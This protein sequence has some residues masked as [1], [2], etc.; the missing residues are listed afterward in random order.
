MRALLALA[1]APVARADRSRRRVRRARE[2]PVDRHVPRRPADRLCRA[3]PGPGRGAADRRSCRRRPTRVS[4]ANGVDQRL[5]GCEFVSNQRLVCTIWG[6]LTY[7]GTLVPVSR[8]VALNIDGSNMRVLGERDTFNQR[9]VRTF[10]GS[11]ID[12][13]PGQENS[14]LMTQ[15]FI[16]DQVTGSR[17]GRR[18]EGLG[19]VRVDTSNLRTSVVE[20]PRDDAVRYI[21]DG[22]GRVR[23]VATRGQRAE[24]QDSPV[25]TYRYRAAGSNDWRDLGSYNSLQDSGVRPVAV[26]PRSQRRL[27]LRAAQWPDGSVPDQARRVRRAR[28]G[29]QPRSGRCRRA[30]PDRPAQPGRRRQ[31]RHRSAAD[32]LFRSR[33]S[34]RSPSSCIARCR[35]CRWSIS[36]T[37]RRT[38]KGC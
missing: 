27:C 37:R 20:R 11:V 25:L 14:L 10:S 1:A 36:S 23:I 12:W 28:A 26:D 5:G 21:A 18:A 30:G 9:Y 2:H 34:Q 33:A 15:S 4:A 8:L 32:R 24:R 22:R 13:L 35:T 6:V 3:D 19:V 16:P 7:E 31:L 29:R 17:V 38:S